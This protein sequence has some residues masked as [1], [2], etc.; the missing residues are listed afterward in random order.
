M[1]F[2]PALRAAAGIAILSIMDAV[3]KAMA[4]HYPIF[5]V[6]FLRFAF[7]SLV[8]TT[9]VTALRPGWP[10]SETIKA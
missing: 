10:S 5:Q 1:H 8:A 2:G 9:L 6:T 3:I 7:G 4:V